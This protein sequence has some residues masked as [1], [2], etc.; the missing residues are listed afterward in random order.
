MFP[1]KID[2]LR[3]KRK[4]VAGYNLPTGGR[5]WVPTN[6]LDYMSQNQAGP[7]DTLSTLCPLMPKLCSESGALGCLRGEH[8]NRRDAIQ[9]EGS[10]LLFKLPHSRRV[11]MAC[12]A[13]QRRAGPEAGEV[14]ERHSTGK[15]PRSPRGSVPCVPF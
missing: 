15:R 14:P 10:A 12:T 9:R 2:W 3:G 4:E 13:R 7:L 11:W 5:F 8:Q 1:A 6:R